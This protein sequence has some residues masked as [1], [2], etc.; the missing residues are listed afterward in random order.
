MASSIRGT[1][2]GW[3]GL[4]LTAVLTVF[5]VTLYRRVQVA[6]L[7]SV[8]AGLQ[9]RARAIAA[10]LEWDP[11]EGWEIELSADYLSGLSADGYFASWAPDGTPL[12]HDVAGEARRP[13]EAPGLYDRG[14]AR[15]VEIE[16]PRGTR[17]LVGRPIRVEQERLAGLLVVIVSAG[18]A[19]L[20]L[21]L[22]GGWWLARRSLSPVDALT[23]AAAA[24]GPG[25]LGVRLDERA[26]PRELRG[27]TRAFNETLDRLQA[28][29]VA[30]SRFTA[31]A[32]HE[33]RTPLT[34]LRTQTERAL[35]SERPVAEYR[36]VLESCLRAAER[37][38]DLVE[39]LLRL[40]RT[41]A[42]AEAL[43]RGPVALDE[44]V[45]EAT[46]TLQPAA[47]ARDVTLHLDAARVS[48]CGDPRLL[49]DAVSNLL[50]NG[51]RYNRPG[52]RVEASL[53]EEN[54]TAI[55]RVTDTG[56]GIPPG[57]ESQLF[58]R[59]YRVDSA[60][61]RANGGV[62]LGLAIVRSIV[63]AHEGSISVASTPGTGT[64]FTIRLPAVTAE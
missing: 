6:T 30:Q 17:V 29:F 23:R 64:E 8:D 63:Q 15:E 25:E 28:A 9:H 55:L 49:A 35:K 26:A 58:E 42:D 59:F 18:G 45:R 7:E 37:M 48:V 53:E 1:L 54:G 4:L 39:R 20:A 12:F 47:R 46:E 14:D 52:G 61:S 41:E 3:F 27:L 56:I 2:I 19:V 43:D 60:R 13:R 57:A 16:G 22:C 38:S 11:Q 34:I 50:D 10:A 62:G 36:A 44:I 24:V 40:A 31:D 33:L 5:G 32:S 21:G 51:I